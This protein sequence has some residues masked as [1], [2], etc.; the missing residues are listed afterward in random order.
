M[1]PSYLLYDLILEIAQVAELNR[2]QLLEAIQSVSRLKEAE[3]QLRRHLK[4][5]PKLNWRL[6]N[7][8]LQLRVV[9]NSVIIYYYSSFSFS[10]FLMTQRDSLFNS[11]L[12]SNTTR[13]Q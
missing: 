12:F 8:N 13:S 2:F 1:W 10:F 3:I 7:E 9:K 5:G 11:L 4:V 6:R